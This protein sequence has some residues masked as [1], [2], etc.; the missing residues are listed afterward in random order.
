M[1]IPAIKEEINL[2]CYLME[3]LLK[4]QVVEQAMSY[5]ISIKMNTTAVKADTDEFLE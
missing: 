3:A 1:K 2:Y 5:S 4:T